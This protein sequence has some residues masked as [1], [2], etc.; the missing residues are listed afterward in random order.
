MEISS[1][2][3]HIL[4]WSKGP[5][6]DYICIEPVMRPVGGLIDDPA[7]VAAGKT[8]VARVTYRLEPEEA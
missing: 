2:Y 1:E 8:L 7:L 4:F 5:G 6:E 3:K